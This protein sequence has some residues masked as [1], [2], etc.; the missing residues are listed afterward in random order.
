MSMQFE[1]TSAVPCLSPEFR[2]RGGPDGVSVYA[3]HLGSVNADPCVGSA[4]GE[5][6]SRLFWSVPT[7][8]R[9]RISSTSSTR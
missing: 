8:S 5:V 6:K 2:K 3:Q 4:G 1:K 9:N 7:I